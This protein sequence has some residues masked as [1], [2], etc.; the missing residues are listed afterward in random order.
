MNDT[1]AIVQIISPYELGLLFEKGGHVPCDKAKA[2]DCYRL[3]SDSGEVRAMYRLALLEMKKD[4]LANAALMRKAARLGNNDA[5]W[6]LAKKLFHGVIL[7]KDYDEAFF[8][9]KELAF[10]NGLFPKSEF[11]MGLCYYNG[12]GTAVDY[13]AAV[14]M[15]FKALESSGRDKWGRVVSHS[16]DTQE[17]RVQDLSDV[18][19]RAICRIMGECHYFGKGVDRDWS[20]ALKYLLL[21]VQDE[22]YLYPDK[23]VTVRAIYGSAEEVS[24]P[25]T[26]AISLR[27]YRGKTPGTAYDSIVMAASYSGAEIS[28]IGVVYSTDPNQTL[29]DLRLKANNA[30][31]S[32][33]EI[34]TG[35]TR[36]KFSSAK[37]YNSNYVYHLTIGDNTEAKVKAIG[38]V[39]LSETD[40]STYENILTT[41]MLDLSYSDLTETKTVGNVQS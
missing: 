28:Y 19:I 29:D 22:H 20:K 12:Y 13:E 24:V 16:T 37:G 21:A 8:W 5:A 7:P 6:W 25:S 1:N 39:Q 15:L 41:E 33:S 40:G 2:A 27:M 34:N 30:V 38:F 9:L 18:D 35:M 17:N 4:P 32:G 26:N 14:R 10:R 23:D 11:L 3:A 36:V 31:M